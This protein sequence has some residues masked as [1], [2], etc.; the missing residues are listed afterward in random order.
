MFRSISAIEAL[1]SSN[2]KIIKKALKSKDAAVR[3]IA[4]GRYLITLFNEGLTEYSNAVLG[5]EAMKTRFI[6]FNSTNE[7]EPELWNDF[8]ALD[9]GLLELFPEL[10][11]F[12][13]KPMKVLELSNLLVTLKDCCVRILNL[14][15]KHTTLFKEE[16][17]K[18]P[19]TPYKSEIISKS[20]KI[21]SY[22]NGYMALSDLAD[23]VFMTVSDVDNL[24][25]N[26][27]RTVLLTTTAYNSLYE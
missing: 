27:D 24:I 12:S 7:F 6:S 9:Q 8:T 22:C 21:K 25:A 5:E 18:N 16:I 19:D 4:E 1:S 14:N 3:R 17:G 23:R 20:N 10:R 13:S 11:V 26:T 2:P 15:K